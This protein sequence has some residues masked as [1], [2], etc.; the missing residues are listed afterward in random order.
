MNKEQYFFIVGRGRSG[1]WLLQSILDHHPQI[2]VTPEAAFMLL[3]QKKYHRKKHWS[4]KEDQSFIRDLWKINRVSKWLKLNK[5][6]LG[7]DISKLPAK[8]NFSDRCKLVYKNYAQ[9]TGKRNLCL[10]GDKMPT[11]SLFVEDISKIMPDA[12][13]IH[14]VREPK[15]TVISYQNVHFDFNNTA[16]LAQRWCVYNNHIIAFK[17]KYPHKFFTLKY[18]DF[19]FKPEKK[20]KDI[21]GF[22]NIP[23]NPLMLESYK[24]PKNILDWN[25]DI[26]SPIK[27]KKANNWNHRMKMKEALLVDYI[28]GDL[29]GDF[30]YDVSDSKIPLYIKMKAT[31]GAL[32]GRIGSKLEKI[33]F[34]L[35]FKLMVRIVNKLDPIV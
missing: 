26:A 24:N 28:C 20:I 27:V 11:Y 23:Y 9:R 6:K 10:F 34:L 12:K 30:G 22:L 7:E 29:A 15:D 2:C 31:A 18:E 32:G 21:C 35:P 1:T 16:V 5:D 13:F 3:L 4:K 33:C 8:S 14:I 17:Q 25:E 19:L